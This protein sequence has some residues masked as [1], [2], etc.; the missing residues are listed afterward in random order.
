MATNTRITSTL[1]VLSFLSAYCLSLSAAQTNSPCYGNI[2]G[3][4]ADPS[5]CR[6]FI[7]CLNGK[8]R[9]YLC[10]NEKI[11]STKS[12]MCVPTSEAIG[13]CTSAFKRTT[14]VSNP[15][16]YCRNNPTAFLPHPDGCALY[17]NC[18]QTKG[19]NIFLGTI[20]NEC[21]YMQLFSEQTLSCQHYSGVRCGSRPE[22]KDKCQYR[23][24]WCGSAHCVPCQI[25]HPSCIGKENGKH[26]VPYRPW[27][28][29]YIEC[30]DE[31]LRTMVNCP[32]VN[33]RSTVFSPSQRRCVAVYSIPSAF[34][35][36]TVSCSN[37]AN[38]FYSDP[39]SCKHFYECSNETI[40]DRFECQLNMVFDDQLATCI[41]AEK[42]CSKC[43]T[44]TNC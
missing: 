10:H 36:K 39:T 31:R 9:R 1:L 28:P 17:Y 43:G 44:K 42:S 5:D 15:N 33:G 14:E 25:R 32:V 12:K 22:P 40:Y 38:G 20:V 30:Q 11:Y 27:S 16:E 4:F 21:P 2:T 29:S 41:A 18:S 19:V 26:P 37:K 3:T 23:R 7:F 13:E 6:Y 34:G 8:S 24:F 35:R